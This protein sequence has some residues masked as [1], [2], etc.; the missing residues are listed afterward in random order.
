MSVDQIIKLTVQMLDASV[1]TASVFF[2]TLLLGLPI[3]MLVCLG[4]MSKL[5]VVRE[6]L[7]LYLLV[8]RGT[9]LLLQLMFFMYAPF[10]LFG[11]S[12]DRFTAGVMAFVFNY[13]AYF[14][15][16]YRGGLESIPAG[17]QEAAIV[18]GFNKTQTFFK[19]TLP[20][21]IKRILP[22]MGNEFMTLVKDTSLIQ[23]LGVAEIY[24]LATST[25]SREAS[26]VPLV[27]AGVFYLVMNAIVSRGFAI[28]EKRLQYY[29]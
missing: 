24:K 25:M 17:Q 8:M 21:V 5:A 26:I 1:T 23:I 28:A 3:G 20:Q 14:A 22:P 9:P 29:R 27:V 15:E 16:I 11:I 18:L 6:P 2:L 4:R 7:K 19:I 12:M 10:H 13:A